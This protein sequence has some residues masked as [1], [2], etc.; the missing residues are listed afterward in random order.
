M[1]VSGP[2]PI[3]AVAIDVRVSEPVIAP[4][5]WTR[6]VTVGVSSTAVTVKVVDA[7]NKVV[8]TDNGT[9]INLALRPTALGSLDKASDVTVNGEV[10][11]VYTSGTSPGVDTLDATSAGLTGA[12]K[13]VTLLTDELAVLK[14]AYLART[15]GLTGDRQRRD[16]GV[17]FFERDVVEPRARLH[18][19]MKYA[20]FRNLLLVPLLLLQY[21]QANRN[22]PRLRII[23]RNINLQ[24]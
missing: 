1:P 24:T 2:R 22:V 12:T 16:V 10:V 18:I 13:N 7:D 5:P 4:L 9:T 19:R 11:F 17:D 21:P 3:S 8:F 23:T 14:G 15:A 20:K 6:H